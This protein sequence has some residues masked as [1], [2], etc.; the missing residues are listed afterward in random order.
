MATKN[1]KETVKKAQ[2]EKI[3]E[4][5][6]RTTGRLSSITPIVCKERTVQL[7]I[8]GKGTGKTTQTKKTI[9]KYIK[10]YPDEKVLIVDFNNEYNEYKKYDNKGFDKIKKPCTISSLSINTLNELIRDFRNGLLVIECGIIPD[11]NTVHLLVAYTSVKRSKDIDVIIHFDS[12]KQVPIRILQNTNGI[13]IHNHNSANIQRDYINEALW[14]GLDIK[15]SPMP[16]NDFS[17]IYVDMMNNKV[18]GASELELYY[19]CMN[20]FTPIISKLANKL[21]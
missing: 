15:N 4:Y 12:I 19:G 13:R 1:K 3:P 11:I 9:K 20:F 14:V 17:F 18:K 5:Y 6:K 16:R 10:K 8:G 21:K 7:V 2:F